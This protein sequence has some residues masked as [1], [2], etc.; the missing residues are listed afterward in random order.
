M[1]AKVFDKTGKAAGEIALPAVFA[2]PFRPDIIKKAVIVAQKNRLQ[3]YGPDRTAGTL[4]SALIPFST[5]L[6]LT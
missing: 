3:P 2:E 5:G 4:T 1:N 6:S